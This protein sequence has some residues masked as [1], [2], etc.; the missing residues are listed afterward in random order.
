MYKI[1]PRSVLV[2]VIL[3][4]ITQ[5]N[6]AQIGI[7]TTT[8]EGA[9]DINSSNNGFIPPRVALTSTIAE[10]PVSNP[11]GGN[12]AEGTIVWN[13]NTAGSAPNNVAPGLYYWN[14][15][16]WISFAGSPGGLDWSLT[17]NSGTTV[18]NDFLGTTD[19]QDFVIATNSFERARIDADGYIGINSLPFFNRR[20]TII[21][22]GTENALLT[23]NNTTAN[24]TL[25][26]ANAAF[27]T[28]VGVL[29]SANGNTAT[30][31]TGGAGV[32]GFSLDSNAISGSAGNGAPNNPAHNGHN[33][34][35]FL[36]DSDNDVSTNNSSAFAYLAGKNESI[37]QA[38]DPQTRRIL[39]GGYF[40]GGTPAGGQSYSYVGLKYNHNNDATAT[41]GTNYKIVGNG[42]V[43]TL[44][45]DENNI[46]RVM[47]CP[48]APEVLFEDY[49]TGQLKNGEVYI[50]L[51]KI[52]AKSLKIDKKHPLKVF[53]QLEGDCNGVY[54]SKKSAIGFKVKELNNGNSNTPFSWHIVANRA[55]TKDENGNITSNFENLR[56]PIGPTP[57][58]EQKMTSK[59]LKL[60]TP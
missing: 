3:G 25:W 50:E 9:L 35:A 19:Y 18:G 23:Y 32:A 51:D 8:P 20:M 17:G 40:S 7:G 11:Q 13:T 12:L 47:F 49:G 15:S 45:P 14:G 55:D 44:I 52:L 5:I 30:F 46:P 60:K 42:T 21:G 58:E 1:S 31:P 43:S 2:V 54:V 33:A 27:G 59:T 37:I 22:S 4:L 38:I 29:G 28:S 10:A 26:G 16:R 34:G 48:E 53:I 41:G 6:H 24:P 57:L 39:Y 36:L 56:L